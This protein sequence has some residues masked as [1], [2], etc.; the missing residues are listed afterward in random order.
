MHF[1]Y[2]FGLCVEKGSE[3]PAG[4]PNRK[5]KYRVVFQGNAVVNQD[6]QA[7]TFD[8]LGSSPGTLESSRACD[9]Y[10]CAPGHEIQMADAEQAYV[11]ALLEGKET[12]ICLPPEARTGP[13]WEKVQHM[14]RPVVRLRLALY[15]HPDSGTCWERHCGQ[16]LKS[17]GFEPMSELWS[18]CYFHHELKLFLVVYVDDFKLAGPSK[19]LERG[20]TLVRKGLQMENPTPI[21]VFLGCNHRV[22]DIRLADGTCA[23][24]MQYD[25]VSFMKSCVARYLE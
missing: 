19:N 10:G 18:S 2:L 21:G 8:D 3:L 13:Q 12:W 22:S 1:D 7:A 14:R 17:V 11:Q 6:W 25:M 20:W 16:H 4:H 23:R 15:G 9:L 24:L 5:F